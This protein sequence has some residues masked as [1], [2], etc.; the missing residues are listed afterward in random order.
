MAHEN[1]AAAA[2]LFTRLSGST[3]LTELVKGRVYNRQA[4]ERAAFPLVIFAFMSGLDTEQAGSGGRVL[5]RP[6]YQV[7]GVTEGGSFQTAARIANAIE[8]ALVG[9]KGTAQFDGH[10]FH[11]RGCYRE[12]PLEY[13]EISEGVR[14]QHVGGLYRLI[15]YEA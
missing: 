9:A 11:F 8:A 6:L 13:D 3:V 4:P 2:F 12:Q 7:K 14:Y 15:L 10:G 1:Y 5:Y